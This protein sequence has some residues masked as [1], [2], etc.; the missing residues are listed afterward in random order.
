MHN[1]LLTEGL[2]HNVLYF[3]LSSFFGDFF[4]PILSQTDDL[5][6]HDGW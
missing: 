6:R 1:Y 4:F 2:S 5:R 3:E